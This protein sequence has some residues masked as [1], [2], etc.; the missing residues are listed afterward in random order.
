[1]VHMF[2]LVQCVRCNGEREINIAS[3]LMMKGFLECIGQI[4]ISGR[5]IQAN[6]G[7]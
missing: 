2:N 3:S 6:S 4:A 7:L 5:L 1:M